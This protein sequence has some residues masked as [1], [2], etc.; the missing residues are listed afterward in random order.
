MEKV[1]VSPGRIRAVLTVSDPAVRKILLCA[2]GF[3]AGFLLSGARIVGVWVPVSVCLTAAWGCTLPAVA[4]WLGAGTGCFL[5]WETEALLL[6]LTTGLLVLSARWGFRESALDGKRW[7]PVVVTALA[8][9][10]VSVLVLLSAPVTA[11]AVV[12]LLLRLAVLPAG[13]TAAD[14]LL[15]RQ[16]GVALCAAAFALISGSGGIL[17][18]GEIPVGGILA[19]AAVF[20]LLGSPMAPVMAALGGLALDWCIPGHG[21]AV[22]VLAAAALAGSLPLS[23]RWMRYAAYCAAAGLTVILSGGENAPL[24]LA[25]VAGGAVG[26][27]LPPLPEDKSLVPLRDA[28]G[29]RL[30]TAAAAMETVYRELDEAPPVRT[31]AVS[32]LYDETAARVCAPCARFQ[33]CWR[34]EA[35]RTCEALEAAAGKFL[36]RGVAVSED[37]P[38]AFSEECRHFPAFLETVNDRMEHT[39][40][41]VQKSR[42]RRE[43]RTVVGGHY[44]V[45]ADYLRLSVL[46]PRALPTPRFEPEAVCRR[47]AKNGVSGDRSACFRQG[48]HSY[49][50]LCDGMGTGP[51]AA[52]DSKRVIALLSRLLQAG[53]APE[54][55][56]EILGGV[57]ILREDGGAATVDLAAIDLTDGT[58]T[59]YKWG[60][61]ASYLV[62]GTEVKRLGTASL[63]PGMGV[64]GTQQAQ[65][66]RL[67]LGKGEVLVLTSDGV[68]GEDA[69][70]LLRQAGGGSPQELAAGLVSMGAW[71][72]EDDR[73]AAVLKLRPLASR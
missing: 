60:S 7:F 59:L 36:H 73:T 46:P 23:K 29:Q 5:L 47:R 49:F 35:A 54:G 2:V 6:N 24:F 27:F 8:D 67:S 39:A 25:A 56:L 61:A 37:F 65:R 63:P 31:A 66:I 3:A 26:L 21:S 62:A 51:E 57:A 9:A 19:A 4:V 48:V 53:M 70:R 69:E 71:Q 43:L 28:A 11:K 42:Y 12:S 52:A 72:A 34:Q 68:G 38:A 13:V 1:R 16:R 22:T 64:G 45:L 32:E 50:L 41:V 10:A 30:R 40:T 14:K 55:A 44:R 58:G 17:L 20:S 33:Q 18:P 15:H